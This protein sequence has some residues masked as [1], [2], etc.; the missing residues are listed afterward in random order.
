MALELEARTWGGIK[1]RVGA[2]YDGNHWV[3]EYVF[4]PNGPT[5]PGENYE[6]V[7]GKYLDEASAFHA[8]NQYVKSLIDQGRT[9]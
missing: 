8:A 4:C 7:P 3:G 5:A 1:Y 2:T 6:I 9:A